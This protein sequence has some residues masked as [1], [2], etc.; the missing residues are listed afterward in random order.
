[1]IS[2]KTAPH[3]AEALCETLLS[4]QS[5]GHRSYCED[6]IGDRYDLLGWQ[7]ALEGC[8]SKSWVKA[9]EAYL[10]SFQCNMNLLQW[11][12]ALIT[13][14]WQIAWNMWDLH[15]SAEHEKDAKILLMQLIS[16][17]EV[18]I[19]NHNHCSDRQLH[20][21]ETIK[22]RS[23]DINDKRV[24]IMNLQASDKR[25]DRKLQQDTALQGSRKDQ[26]KEPSALSY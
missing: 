12:S 3:L 23:S 15:N 19:T 14:M 21:S 11:V 8:L 13:K 17:I 7:L 26:L 24:W 10:L 5:N 6:G 16:N 4:W 18:L 2:N 20:P 22:L 1:M 9:Q 25:E